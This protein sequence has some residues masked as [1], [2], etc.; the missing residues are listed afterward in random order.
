MQ[1]RDQERIEN[2]LSIL[3]GLT[4]NSAPG[5]LTVQRD[6]PH[7]RH[8]DT[9]THF[10]ELAAHIEKA[11]MSSDGQIPVFLDCE[12]RDLGREGGK[13]GLV[14][15]GVEREVYLVD[16]IACPA[17]LDTLKGILENPRLDKIV[18]DGRSDW[19]ELWFGHGIAIGPLIDLQ[20]V[21]VYEMSGG[22]PRNTG[23]YIMLDGMGKVFERA[24]SSVRQDSG[25]VM[26]NFFKGFSTFI[27]SDVVVQTKVKAKHG[28]DDTD[29]WVRRPIDSDCLDYASYDVLQLRS[30]YNHYRSEISKR[31]HISTESKRYAEMFRTQRRPKRS[32]YIDHGLL[33][34]E[35]LERSAKNKEMYD[36]L[37]TRSCGGCQRDLH[38]DSFRNSFSKTWQG[39]LCHTCFERKRFSENRRY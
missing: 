18:W 3:Q 11:L 26:T 5:P 27:L 38:Q 12:G 7:Y 22:I 35:I 20:L 37:G 23:G 21:R 25:I 15:L 32:F 14:Q 39:Y 36:N 34:Q 13:L 29:F 24:P 9:E 31:P 2:V 33:P 4:I 30:L 6:S 28:R 17:S 1:N 10:Q 19:C 8:C 16:V